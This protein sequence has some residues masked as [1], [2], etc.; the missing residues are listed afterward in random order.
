MLAAQGNTAAALDDY[1]KGL[2]IAERMAAADP[3]NTE[4]QRDLSVSHNKI[5]NML[6]AQGNTAAALDAYRKG[7]VIR[8]RLAAA[9]PA[10]AGWQTDVV[11]SA[12]KLTDPK[13]APLP[14]GEANRLLARARDILLKLEADQRL[15]PSQTGWRRLVEERIKQLGKT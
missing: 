14:D 3:R 12:F 5:G 4:W 13:F 15:L 9:D 1:R 6:V 8:E 7:L 10:H 11:I 2:V